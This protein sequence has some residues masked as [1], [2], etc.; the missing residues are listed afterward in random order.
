MSLEDSS[1]VTV[2]NVKYKLCYIQKF[3]VV[4]L[5]YHKYFN[6]VAFEQKKTRNISI[7]IATHHILYKI[8]KF[9][10]IETSNEFRLYHIHLLNVYTYFLF[11][12]IQLQTGML[13]TR[14]NTYLS[15]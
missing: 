12:A 6:L 5:I 8:K 2:L 3:Y 11:K 14:T 7:E 10:L 9:I 15:T 1:Y 4:I 13:L